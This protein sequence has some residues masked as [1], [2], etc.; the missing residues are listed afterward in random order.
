MVKHEV[1]QGSDDSDELEASDG[2]NVFYGNGGNDDIYGGKNIDFMFGG[3]GVILLGRNGTNIIF[4]D[5]EMIHYDG[6]DSSTQWW[7]R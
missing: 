2:F 4:G 6:D 3:N 1:I 5:A 7:R